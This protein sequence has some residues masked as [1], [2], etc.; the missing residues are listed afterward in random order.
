MRKLIYGS[1]LLLTFFFSCKKDPLENTNKLGG[2]H[3][4]QGIKT[5]FDIVNNGLDT[6]VDIAYQLDFQEKILVINKNMI[7]FYDTMTCKYNNKNNKII[8]YTHEDNFLYPFRY[9]RDTL[10]YNYSNGSIEF[11]SF[12]VNYLKLYKLVLFSTN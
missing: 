1:L 5:L 12:A 11:R 7:Y 4:W 3:S 2:S 9:S 6:T 10:I 8:E